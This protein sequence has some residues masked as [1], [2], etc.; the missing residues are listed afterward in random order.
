[1][2]HL[3]SLRP[4][5]ILLIL[6]IPLLKHPLIITFLYHLINDPIHRKRIHQQL[7]LYILTAHEAPLLYNLILIEAHF[8]V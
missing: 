2:V 1:M 4:L 5:P 6:L 7:I 3:L 8:T